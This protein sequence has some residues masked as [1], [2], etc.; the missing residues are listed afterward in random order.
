MALTAGSISINESTGE[1]SGSGASYEMLDAWWTDFGSS[2]YSEAS[3]ATIVAVK[4]GMGATLQAIAD[5]MVAA[6]VEASKSW[7]PGSIAAGSSAATTLTLTDLA[8][9]EVVAIHIW[10]SVAENAI[11]PALILSHWSTPGT[12]YVYLYN[13]TAAA[14]NPGSLQLKARRLL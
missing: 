12:L 3:T 10:E 8:L 7:S 14:I 4:Q 2:F 13:P 5:G 1:H 9:A 6:P 11:N